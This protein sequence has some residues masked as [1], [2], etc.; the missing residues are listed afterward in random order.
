MSR[1]RPKNFFG[2]LRLFFQSLCLFFQTF[3][4]CSFSLWTYINGSFVRFFRLVLS[5]S[6]GRAI[7]WFFQHCYRIWMVLSWV[8]SILDNIPRV[9]VVFA[10]ERSSIFSFYHFEIGFFFPAD[11]FTSYR[12]AI[13]KSA[14]TFL[15]VRALAAYIFYL[16][17]K[18]YAT[19]NR[20]R[21]VSL[22]S[23]IMN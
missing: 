5:F 18:R 15:S 14:D 17:N 12:P 4:C 1:K 23:F 3:Q 8:L 11:L 21:M 7:V 2:S 19:I 22:R 13:F 6:C 16:R 9:Y 10:V 20:I